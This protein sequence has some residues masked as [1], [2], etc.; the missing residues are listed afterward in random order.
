M[1]D[2][3]VLTI[4]EESFSISDHKKFNPSTENLF[5]PNYYRLGS[6]SNFSCVQNPTK[7]DL[8][9][10]NYKPRLTVTKR[11]KKGKFEITLRIEFSI[12]KLL[13]GNNF[14]EVDETDFQTVI[15][16]L[17]DKLINMGVLVS[18]DN[19]SRADVS[20]VHF[21]KNILLTDFTTPSFILNELSKINLTQ[22]LDI[23][24]T[25]YR[26]EGHCLKFHSNSFEIVFYDKLKDLNKAKTSEKRAIEKDNFI[27]FDLFQENKHIKPFEVIRI[28]V[29]L[30]NRTKLKQIFKKIEIQNELTFSSIFHK[31]LSQKVLLHF[32]D[33]IESDYSLLVYKP[34]TSKDFLTDLKTANP[35]I[36]LRKLLQLFGLKTAIEEMGIREFREITKLFG[37]NTWYRIKKDYS[38][39]KMPLNINCN[40]IKS[41]KNALLD[42]QPL[43]LPDF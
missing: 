24:Q 37:N 1:I 41:L 33:Q 40:W 12:P 31:P 25:D 3:V 21:S 20:A 11:M 10:G 30:N 7:S 42:F 32:F 27:Q 2:T 13:F 9:K 15:L 35:N 14:D 18:H 43:K 23:N 29:R 34:K 4:S 36:K 38:L 39:L 17:H 19:L 16:V 8:K 22:K 6:R 5:N 26:N 28:E